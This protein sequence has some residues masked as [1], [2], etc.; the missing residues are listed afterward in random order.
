MRVVIECEDCTMQTTPLQDLSVILTTPPLGTTNIVASVALTY[1]GLHYMDGRLSDPLEKQE[2]ADLRWYL[3]EY[4]QWPYAEFAKR[5]QVV[6]HKLA[7]IGK[8]LYNSLCESKEADRIM[9]AWLAAPDGQQ[10]LSIITDI[11]AVL[12]LPWE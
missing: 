5:G 11:P 12:S 3:E 9:Q 10:Q 8:H 1:S 7:V 4:W 2:R 6:E